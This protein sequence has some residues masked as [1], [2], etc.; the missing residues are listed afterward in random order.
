[1]SRRTLIVM[2]LVC[3]LIAL[4]SIFTFDQAIAM[5]VHNSG[6]ENTAFFVEGRSFLDVFTGRGLVG[7]H[8]GLGQF[9]LGGLFIIIGLIAFA[10]RRTSYAARALIFT[11]VVQ[12]LTIETAWQIKDVFGRMRPYQLI[13]KNDWSHMWFTGSNSFP[14][15]HNAFFWGLFVP[16]MYLYPRW[17]IPLLIVPIFIALARVDEN[18]HFLSDVLASV[19]LACLITLLAAALFKRWLDAQTPSPET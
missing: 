19:A 6:F 1:V 4:V 12:W 2:A 8:V 9:L 7:S 14:S 16:L 15:G 3:A 18:Y 11:G 5:A 13:E 10:I 17:R